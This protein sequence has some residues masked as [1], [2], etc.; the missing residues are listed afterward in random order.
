[1]GPQIVPIYDGGGMLEHDFH[2]VVFMIANL[3]MNRM[4][5]NINCMDDTLN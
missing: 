1:M 5:S 3:I 4:T 2:I